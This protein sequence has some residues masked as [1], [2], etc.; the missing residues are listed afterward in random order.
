MWLSATEANRIAG[1]N[2]SAPIAEF[3]I[4]SPQQISYRFNPWRWCDTNTYAP[5][6]NSYAN[7]RSMDYNI[8][9]VLRLV[10][11]ISGRE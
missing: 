4:Q 1:G 6:G 9:S 8:S 3:N 5:L 7:L 2:I 10:I 11:Y